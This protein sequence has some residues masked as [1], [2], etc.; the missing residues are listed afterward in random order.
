MA[1]AAVL[2]ATLAGWLYWSGASRLSWSLTPLAFSAAVLALSVLLAWT[3]ARRPRGAQVAALLVLMLVAGPSAG[4]LDA[5]LYGV[6]ND[7]PSYALAFAAC[8]L[9]A[10][11]LIGQHRSGSAAP[12]WIIPVA[13]IAALLLLAGALMSACDSVTATR[14]V[15]A[16]S[17]SPDGRWLAIGVARTG[18]FSTEAGGSTVVVRRDLAG[19]LRQQ[20]VVYDSDSPNEPR[21]RW[22]DPT[23]LS[24]GQQM[25]TIRR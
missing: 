5:A 3:Q 15:F 23:T 17:R 2:L 19:L 24:V 9:L 20:V 7:A 11:F 22:L 12:G 18:F 10:G 25:R 8:L 13:S 1:L 16:E 6:A 21:V 14:N 4:D